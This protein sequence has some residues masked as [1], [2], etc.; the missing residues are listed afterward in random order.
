MKSAILGTIG[1]CLFLNIV[2]I[3]SHRITNELSAILCAI[4]TIILVMGTLLYLAGIGTKPHNYSLEY[5]YLFGVGFFIGI[6]IAAS[7]VF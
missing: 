7:Y 1:G 6:I 3:A 4:E 5:D 2:L